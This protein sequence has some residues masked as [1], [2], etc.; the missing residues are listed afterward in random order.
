MRLRRALDLARAAVDS[1]DTAGPS[2]DVVD[3][4]QAASVIT[5]DLLLHCHGFC[6]A[7]DGHHRSEDGGLFPQIAAARPDLVPVLDKLRQDHSMMAHL[8]RGLQQALTRGEEADTL[9][10]HLDGLGA[11][12][13]THFGFEERSLLAVLDGIPIDLQRR[14]AFGEIVD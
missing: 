11:V 6:A 3:A 13:E 2:G 1:A 14:E 7:L 10:Q 4:S 9:H 12:M 5:A 8:I